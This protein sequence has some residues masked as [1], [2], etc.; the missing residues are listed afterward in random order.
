MI[1][2]I[3]TI[4]PII[5]EPRDD[6]TGTFIMVASCA[7]PRISPI[8]SAALKQCQLYVTMHNTAASVHQWTLERCRTTSC[9]L[10]KVR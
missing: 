4:I 9:C 6:P 1:V 7:H 8:L 2:L 5:R 10:F 3:V